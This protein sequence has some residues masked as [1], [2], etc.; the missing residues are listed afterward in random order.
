MNTKKQR[1]KI[2]RAIE[3]AK[4]NANRKEKFKRDIILDYTSFGSKVYAPLTRDGHNPDRHPFQ[5]LDLHSDDLTSFDGISQLETNISEK[6]LNSKVDII[7]LNKQYKNSLKKGEVRHLQSIDGAFESIK[8]HE[9]RKIEFEREEERRRIEESKARQDKTKT[10]DKKSDEI[11]YFEDIVLLQRLLRGRRE[12][13]V[14]HE[15]KNKRAELIKE[16]RGAV[17]WKKVSDTDNETKLIDNYIE[18]LMNGVVDAI[19]GQNISATL[20]FLSK[21][22][23]RIKEEMKINA[24]V[25]QAENE[26]RRREAE[27]MGRRQAENLLRERQDIL[28]KGMLQVN[29]ATMDSYINSII[30]GTVNNVSK[31]QV[32]KELEIKAH[33]L[34]IIVD[35]IENKLVKDDVVVRDLVSSF[36]I[37]DINR[38]KVE[39]KSKF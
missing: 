9:Q 33:K 25:E 7:E 5:L 32:M 18:K 38:K 27:E 24:I 39:D 23:I 11:S 14:M 4:E 16:L 36:I 30:S 15:G 6:H 31:K 21:E 22:K 8:K 13:I 37:P 1:V 2:I 17:E 34:N 28:Y 10:S 19:Q 12:Q 20:D 29:Q 26:R 3:K 35:K